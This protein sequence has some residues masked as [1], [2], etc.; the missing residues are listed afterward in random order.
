MT[1]LSIDAKIPETSTSL[2]IDEPQPLKKRIWYRT[3]LFNAFVIGGV[4]F[5]A[6]GLWNAMNALGAGGAQSPFLVNAANSLVFSLMGFLCL[7][8]GPISNRIGLSW[9]LLLGAVG[10]PIY[11]AGLYCNNRYGTVWLVLVGATTCGLSAG[12]F[13]ASEGAVALGYPEPGKRGLYMN[14]WLWFR[15]GGPLMGG[16]IVLGLNHDANAA[17]KGKV[18]YQTYLVFIALQCVSVPLALALSPPEKV[19]RADGSKV[20][21]RSESSFKAEFKKLWQASTRKD[22]LLLLPIFWAAYF[23]QYTGNFQTYYFGVRARAL[24]GFCSYLAGLLSSQII[25]TLL[26]YKAFAIKKRIVL[27]F[28]YVI[29]LHIIAWTYAWIVQEQYTSMREAPVYDWAD[30]G[31]VKGFFVV[32]LWQFSQQALQNFMYYL[33]ATKTDNISD[34]ARFSGILRGQESF[35]QAVS[36]GIN[37]RNWKGGRVPLAVN[38]ILLGL[39]VFPTWIVVRSHVPVEA[40]KEEPIEVVEVSGRS[41]AE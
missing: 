10:Y 23:N 22:I 34:L 31:F 5:M 26:D 2:P 7:F 33:L 12:L 11:S 8:G 35:A 25:S 9:T 19:Q 1:A 21:V 41:D 13:W 18:G 20:I 28:Y 32:A 15:T 30:Q 16:A 3:T 14:I 6:P 24:M 39:A 17:K 4:G 29:T 37:S 40:P 27:A 38:T 36:Y